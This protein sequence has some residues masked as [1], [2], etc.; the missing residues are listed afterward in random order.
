M[1]RFGRYHVT[2]LRLRSCGGNRCHLLGSCLA[3]K[4]K[5]CGTR[6][7]AG[8]V[9]VNFLCL[10]VENR[11]PLFGE[12]SVVAIAAESKEDVYTD[13]HTFRRALY[14]MSW[15]N[16]SDR[17][18]SGPQSP[19]SLFV[20]VEKNVRSGVGMGSKPFDPA[21]FTPSEDW[22]KVKT[23]E[24]EPG[25]LGRLLSLTFIDRLLPTSIVQRIASPNSRAIV[26]RVPKSTAE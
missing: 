25:V 3:R 1:A 16:V 2:S 23:I 18:R 6:I 19:N 5:D 17:V 7:G 15:G 26:Y 21:A 8:I 11:E 24:P 4:L 20:Y 9:S 12:R 13:P 14:P 22:T 10:L